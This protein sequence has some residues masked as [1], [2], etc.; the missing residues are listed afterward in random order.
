MP[1]N[2]HEHLTDEQIIE[3]IA[4]PDTCHQT[5]SL[6]KAIK[7]LADCDVCRAIFG[8]WLRAVTPEKD[9]SQKKLNIN[10]NVYLPED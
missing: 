9:L 1:M 3:I 7:H 4:E 10:I 2:F 6:K 5:E 8:D